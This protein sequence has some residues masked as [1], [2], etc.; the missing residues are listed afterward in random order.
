MRI[1][2]IC[3]FVTFLLGTP[4]SWAED[5][6]ES[7]SRDAVLKADWH[8]LAEITR[9]WKQREPDSAVVNWLLIG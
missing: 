1:A 8:Q 3:S 2:L 5:G 9:E 4:F 6:G 7:A